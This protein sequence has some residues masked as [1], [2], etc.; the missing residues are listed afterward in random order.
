MAKIYYRSL[1][2]HIKVE[3]G[4]QAMEDQ[5]TIGIMEEDGKKKEDGAETEIIAER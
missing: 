3:I 5:I 1:H 4:A 2:S